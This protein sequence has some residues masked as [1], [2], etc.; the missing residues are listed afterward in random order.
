MA[1]D[2]NSTTLEVPND[3]QPKNDQIIAQT[4]LNQGPFL[5]NIDAKDFYKNSLGIPFSFQ[6]H[7]SLNGMYRYGYIIFDDKYG[8]RETLP[9]T[10]NEIITLLYK[11]STR[12]SIFNSPPTI[13]HFNVFDIEETQMA[14][15]DETRF[16]N[17][18]LKFHVIEAPF[19][20]KY[21][22]EV[23][24]RSYGKNTGKDSDLMAVD[25]IFKTHLSE[26]LKLDKDNNVNHIDFDL[27]P[28]ATKLHFYTPAWKSQ[29]MFNYLLPFCKDTNN[30]EHVKFF[31][32]TDIKSGKI[33]INMKSM[34]YMFSQKNMTEFT[35]LDMSPY[36]S[37]DKGIDP[38]ILNQILSYKFISYDI[39]SLTTGFAG[40]SLLNFNYNKSK[41]YTLQNTYEEMIKKTDNKYFYNFGL[42][43]NTISSE[44]SMQTYLGPFPHDQAR[45][46]ID[47]RIKE[48]QYQL[49]CETM[50]YVD[51]TIQIGDKIFVLFQS[52]MSDATKDIGH[53]TDEQMSGG[54]L[55][56]EIIDTAI[57]GLGMRKMVLVK[58]SFFNVY[59][60]D[61]RKVLPEV[62]PVFNPK[63]GQAMP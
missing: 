22:H 55:V 4:Y 10:G 58:D 34:N 61:K 28:M 45:T 30:F 14:T 40:G 3:G 44:R 1:T 25:Q 7:T 18:A 47:N 32:T 57:N 62:N 21:N 49:R 53:L 35:T 63:S 17:K 16:S 48:Q 19:F 39:T 52:G 43:S 27:Q 60:S 24:K 26:D 38:R 29:T 8:I 37:Y 20:L 15:Y 33:I 51:E 42:W 2:A 46:Y 36:S 13:I 12:G 6:I 31:T 56:E 9:L 23:W 5:D 41:Y 59:M 11:N 54:W 50:T